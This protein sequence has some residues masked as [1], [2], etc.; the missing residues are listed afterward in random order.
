MKTI[1]ILSLAALMVF[2]LFTVSCKKSQSA[3]TAAFSYTPNPGKAT[4]QV[5]FNYTGSGAA[6]YSWTFGDG[7]A[8]S[9]VENPEHTYN[10]AGSYNVTLSV[11]NTTGSAST[12]QTIVVTP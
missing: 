2:G 9:I 5:Q 11:S 8:S 7:S 10:T 3:P 12:S 1:K 6:T 4:Q